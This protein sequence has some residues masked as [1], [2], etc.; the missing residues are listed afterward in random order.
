[1]SEER[2]AIA[3]NLLRSRSEASEGSLAYVSGIQ[4]DGKSIRLRLRSRSG[5]WI[6]LW[7]RRHHVGN[8]RLKA[9]PPEHPRY[10]DSEM[11]WH[12]ASAEVVD[13]LNNQI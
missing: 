5:R 11:S 3:C 8:Y 7:E 4:G 9:I 2:V 10:G 6:T 1:M 13:N 12:L